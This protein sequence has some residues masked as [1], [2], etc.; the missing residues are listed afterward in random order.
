MVNVFDNME[1]AMY[2]PSLT[3][4]HDQLIPTPE[5]MTRPERLGVIKYKMVRCKFYRNGKGILADHNHVDFANNVWQWTFNDSEIKN[6]KYGGFDIELPRVNDIVERK[7]HSVFVKDCVMQNNQQM[8]FSVNGYYANVTIMSSKF[9]DNT[10]LRGLMY[11]GGM[12]KDLTVYNNLFHRNVG[13]YVIELDMTSH[14]EYFDLGAGKFH[15]NSISDNRPS[16]SYSCVSAS[17]PTTYAVAIRGVLDITFNR[18]VFQNPLLQFELI[19]GIYSLLVNNRLNVKENWW[20]TPVQYAIRQKIF[21]FDDWNSYVIAD[22]FPHLTVSDVINDNAIATGS[23]DNFQLNLQKLGGRIDGLV[24]LPKSM[25]PYKVVS[26]LTIMPNAK[27]II[28]PGSV[29]HFNPNV[30]IL[31]LGQLVARGSM[32]SRIKFAPAIQSI[33]GNSC[34]KKRSTRNID[35]HATS[36]GDVR[37]RRDEN[38][39][40][41][42]HQGFLELYN[43]TTDTWTI[44]CDSKF[45]KKTAEVVCRELGL[46]TVNVDIRFTHLF[47]HY[48]FGKPMY[49]R[50][51]FWTYSYYC[52]GDEPSLGHCMKRINYD[53]QKCIHASNYTFIRCGERTLDSTMDYWGNIR[54]ASKTYEEDIVPVVP[55]EQR[56]ALEYVDIDGAGMLH[57]EKVGAVQATYVTP[58]MQDIN[59][60]R[61]L[62][63]GFDIVSPRYELQVHNINASRNLGYGINVLMLN[64]ESSDDEK[65]SF[66]PLIT[67]TVPYF[68]MGLVD[69]CRMEKEIF[70]EN[71]VIVYYKYSQYERSCV[72]V[73]EGNNKLRKVSFRL[74]Q[75]N[76]YQDDFYRNVIEVF[77]GKDVSTNTLITELTSNSTNDDITRRYLATGHTISV[78]IHASSAHEH[79]GFIAEIVTSPLSYSNYPGNFIC[80]LWQFFGIIDKSFLRISVIH[81]LI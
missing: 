25:I 22:Y 62:W 79:Y 61:C 27:L 8:V 23:Q 55:D 3:K 10:C 13:K 41:P 1:E 78:H 44:M 74:L 67:N 49:F 43:S 63:N 20:G 15:V 40:I 58:I 42:I 56:S 64:G 17:T 21:D 4:Y 9:V 47:D 48:I 52:N 24:S 54:F 38:G 71:R 53:I 16:P 69:I 35:V 29:L 11:I 46:E 19:A 72:K 37:L 39:T 7:Y 60:T 57:G 33:V 30:G 68:M 65:S 28:P 18:N 70:L 6:N 32:Y 59:V 50:K 2:I 31:V 51:E 14:S 45:N 81:V 73:I 76:L 26:D 5:E 66:I 36:S 80:N 77:D 75:F 12:E 34:I